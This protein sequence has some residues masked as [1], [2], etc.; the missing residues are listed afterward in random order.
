MFARKEVS[1]NFQTQSVLLHPH[2]DGR[3]RCGHNAHGSRMSRGQ[4][5]CACGYELRPYSIP[6]TADC[7]GQPK[8]TRVLVQF[9]L[10]GHISAMLARMIPALAQ[11]HNYSYVVA[12]MA[13]MASTA[14]YYTHYNVNI[15]RGVTNNF[16]LILH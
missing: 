12:S 8:Q 10:S 13:S 15:Y 14:K 2:E 16:K 4:G 1:F 3:A 9:M 6:T 11:K 5:Y 7:T